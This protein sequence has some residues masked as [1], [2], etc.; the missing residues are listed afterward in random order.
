MGRET[1]S[2]KENPRPNFKAARRPAAFRL[3]LA[4]RKR[5]LPMYP[6]SC[7][8]QSAYLSLI[9]RRDTYSLPFPLPGG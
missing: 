9:N 1:K 3:I 6:L 7:G 4:L 2:G 5:Q 8:N